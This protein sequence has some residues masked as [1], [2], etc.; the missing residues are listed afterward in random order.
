[1]DE[2]WYYFGS[3][4]N[5]LLALVALLVGWL[6]ASIIA[7]LVKK[8]L[9][10]TDLDNKLFT[11]PSG[12]KKGN[13]RAETIIS[14]FVFW[15]IMIFAFVIFLN[16]L[17]LSIIAQ[18]FS[19]ILTSLLSIIPSIIHAII[20]FAVAWIIAVTLSFL[21]RKLGQRL[22]IDN[23]LNKLGLQEE[24]NR[25]EKIITTISTLVFYF[26]LL[27]FLPAILTTLNITGIAQPF[28]AMVSSILDF[29]PAL[30]A[31]ALVFLIGWFVAKVIR[32]LLTNFLVNVGSEQFASKVGLN[33]FLEG[34]SLAQVIGTIV[35]ILIMI[36]V[37][38]SALEQLN[39]SGITTPAI[40]MLNDI[41]SMIPNIAIAIVLIMVGIWIGRW[42]KQLVDQLLARM[43]FNNLMK[44]LG[45]DKWDHENPPYTLSQ[46][47]GIIAEFVIIILFIGE[48]LQVVNLVFLVTIV[49]SII[50]YLPHVLVA[51]V[52][53][54]VA[55]FLA[56]L[57][58]RIVL[59]LIS[60]IGRVFIANIAKYAI[61]VLSVF[62]ALNQL[63][64]ADSIV[65]AAF[66]LILGGLA[67]AFGLAFGLGGR[68]F[69]SKFLAKWQQKLEYTQLA[70]KNSSTI[71]SEEGPNR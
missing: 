41:M 40:G 59:S 65:N 48:A 71:D 2:I 37:T 42:V 34:T 21:I 58:E 38:I 64:V 60:G 24:E 31:A 17:N 10:K 22:P 29:I 56:H 12:E 70:P 50:A 46:I 62:M 16:M 3:I 13:Q 4:S 44:H 15:L 45:L 43:G 8:A 63:G 23:I 55:L 53:L 26:V 66:I 1:M 69:A 49:G 25:S 32:A 36:P 30:F 27:I 61:I 7:S 33:K 51:I 9:A 52:I 18:P 35:F 68:E 57:V 6:I 14:K 11:G 67:L 19:D 5:F 54:A 28:Q 20:L 47:V 39:I